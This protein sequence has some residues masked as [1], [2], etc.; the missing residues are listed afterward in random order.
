MNDVNMGN[1]FSLSEVNEADVIDSLK[2]LKPSKSCR[3]DGLTAR[4]LKDCKLHIVSP[5]LNIFNLSIRRSFFPDT[6]KTSVVTPL[7]KDG[8]WDEANNYRPISLLSLMSKLLERIVHTQLYDYCSRNNIL[9]SE[10]AGFRKGHSTSSCLLH[11]LDG[12]FMDIDEGA[13]CGVLFLDLKKAFDSAHDKLLLHKLK[14][15][16]HQVC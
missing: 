5:L 3:I 1:R 6:W 8:K 2:E 10:Q 12:I 4:L 13:A 9:S 14:I 16:Y 15:H 11:F 7:Y